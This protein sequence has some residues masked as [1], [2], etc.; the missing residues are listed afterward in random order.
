MASKKKLRRKI[1]KQEKR[2]KEL[3]AVLA[4]RPFWSNPGLAQLAFETGAVKPIV[5]QFSNMA[6][7][8]IKSIVD[9]KDKN[10]TSSTD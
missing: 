2:I 10:G 4:A 5:Q 3:E 9:G 1:R 7:E 6:L 8:Q